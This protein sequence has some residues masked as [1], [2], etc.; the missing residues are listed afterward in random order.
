MRSLWERWTLNSQPVPEEVPSPL[1]AWLEAN[2]ALPAW[3]DR[4]RMGR[5]SQLFVTHAPA[6]CLVLGTASLVELYA[7]AKG[8][9]V[10]AFTGR[11]WRNPYRRIGQTVQFL[12]DVMEPDGFAPSGRGIRSIQ[13]VRL[14]HAGIR[15]L[16]GASGEW[17][18]AALG[19][20]INQEEL[21]GTL[22]TF[23]YTVC[24]NLK[25]FDIALSP[26]E[27]EDFLYFWRVVGE[28]LGVQ[29]ALIPTSMAEAEATAKLIF[30]RQQAP[31]E[32]GAAMTQALLQMYTA[33]DP[34]HLFARMIPGVIRYTVG[35]QVADWLGVPASRWEELLLEATGGLPLKSL[36]LL[37][38]RIGMWL[39]TR[40]TLLMEGG[41]LT[42]FA[43]PTALRP[44]LAGAQAAADVA[45]PEAHAQR[46]PL[47]PPR[48]IDDVLHRLDEI[49][50]WAYQERSPVGYFAALYKGTT[51]QI[52]AMIAA[53]GFADAHRMERL[54]VTFASRY[55]AAYE[56]YRNGGQTTAAWAVAFEAAASPKVSILQHLLLGMNAHINLDLGV[57]TA[58]ICPGPSILGIRED[59]IKVNHVMAAKTSATDQ[60]MAKLS[61][62]S[63][64]IERL[65]GKQ[66]D[67]FVLFDVTMARLSA[68]SV[69]EELALAKPSAYRMSLQ[70]RDQA[71]A[72]IGQRIW[73]PPGL[74]RPAARLMQLTEVH[75]VRRVIGVLLG[76]APA[77]DS[78]A[79]AKAG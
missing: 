17:D 77:Q 59:F 44:M 20:P 42:A 63:R 31:S 8:V 60:M 32:A 1:R 34:T 10:L 53:G 14:M 72:A 69:A 30:G 9:E 39:L 28:M 73:Q 54:D 43:I 16:I 11:L 58:Q 23:S 64:V 19:H 48:T 56:A 70:A 12:L 65:A 47:A 35:D 38:N 4:E 21:L 57:A 41:E 51:Q 18:E 36:S 33:H 75:D 24:A 78:G 76:S 25:R 68:W 22:M 67:E 61:P 7:C 45:L 79:Q 50:A 74:L 66:E 26:T 2:S 62:I 13:K 37:G 55:L 3:A 46:L 29:P 49:I 15:N 52:K 71:V 27:E 6:I 40:G 5:A